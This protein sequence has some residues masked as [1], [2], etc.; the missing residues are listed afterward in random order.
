MAPLWRASW[1]VNPGPLW[2]TNGSATATVYVSGA[3]DDQDHDGIPDT[4]ESAADFDGDNLPNFVDEDA[5]ND[6]A[7]DVEEGT[8]DQDHDGQMDFLD[9][10][11]GP[12]SP[13][14]ID[15]SPQEPLLANKLYLPLVAR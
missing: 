9:P 1:L 10:N 7:P 14:D 5:D 3:L 2:T 11:N 6:G 13:T 15:V 4:I 12:P 8:A